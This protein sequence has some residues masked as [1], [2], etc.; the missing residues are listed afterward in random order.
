MGST[1]IT[2][3]EQALGHF[4]RRKLKQLDNWPEWEKGEHKQL[5]QF[6]YQKMFGEPVDASTL[7]PASI[8]L[9]P[10]WQYQVKRDGTRRSRLCCDGSKRAAPK[11]HE[12]AKTWSSCLEQPVQRLFLALCAIHGF[13]IYGA[14]VRDA[15]AHA[16]ADTTTYLAIDDA[17]IDWS[18]KVLGK[19]VT[20][21]QVL[22][23][24]HSLQGSPTSGRCWMELV[25]SILIKI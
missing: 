13:K 18:K 17:Y 9:R 10:H 24:V 21:S 8:I 2:P 20:K 3:A 19:T 25:D 16:L 22:P 12:L 6:Y 5:N 15:F 4:T 23:I 11:L 14:D 1:A 7:D